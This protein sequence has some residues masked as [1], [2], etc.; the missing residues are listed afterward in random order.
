[1]KSQQVLIVAGGVFAAVA[2]GFV[3]HRWRNPPPPPPADA[4]LVVP[5]QRI[6]PYSLGMPLAE[7]SAKRATSPSASPSGSA[8]GAVD[9]WLDGTTRVRLR[10][11]KVTGVSAIVGKAGVSLDGAW[12]PNAADAPHTVRALAGSLRTCPEKKRPGG[13]RF[14][15][16]GTRFDADEGRGEVVVAIGSE[17]E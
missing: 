11:G 8:V 2:V 14:E 1:M 15:C 9:G 4:L 10:D 17:L 13:V 5:G 3:V 7:A 16:Y 12:I 6:G